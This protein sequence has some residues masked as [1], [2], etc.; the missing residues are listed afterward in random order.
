[1]KILVEE[2]LQKVL[3]LRREQQGLTQAQLGAKLGLSAMG[4]SYL[5]R[6]SRG[7]KL[8]LLELWAEELGLE[9]EIRL[10]KKET[11]ESPT[12]I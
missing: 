6:G 9:V 11:A 8:E 10:N 3:K 1:M 7:L 5:E 2:S 12:E 4:L